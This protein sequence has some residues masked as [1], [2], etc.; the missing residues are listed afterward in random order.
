M[1]NGHKHFPNYHWKA[2]LFLFSFHINVRARQPSMNPTIKM[3]GQCL[4]IFNAICPS[5]H[6]FLLLNFIP[7]FTLIILLR[8]KPREIPNWVKSLIR[9]M[10]SLRAYCLI[11][12][13]NDLIF[14]NIAET[15]L[16]FRSS[17]INLRTCQPRNP[18][19]KIL[20]QY[21]VLCAL[22]VLP[23]LLFHNV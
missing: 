11:V 14:F 18:A 16:Y 1:N 8:T 10:K 20:G 23:F 2:S 3:L 22:W 6:H 21:H 15:L 5:H 13:D 12:M 19:I 17:H 7:A 4:T 9:W